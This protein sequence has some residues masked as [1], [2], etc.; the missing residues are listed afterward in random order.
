[1]E[2]AIETSVT[3]MQRVKLQAEVLVPLLRHLRAELPARGR[4]S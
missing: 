2:K 3:L 1:M 4:E